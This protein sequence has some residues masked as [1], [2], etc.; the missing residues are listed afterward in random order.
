M[1]DFKVGDKVRLASVPTDIDPVMGALFGMPEVG[2]EG[3]VSEF[4]TAED[5]EAG[6]P[7][8]A[9]Y[10]TF[11]ESLTWAGGGFGVVPAD[12]EAV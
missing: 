1:T 3:V 8:D 7:E 11:P 9:F 5:I 12:V 6:A 4:V 10:V 2:A